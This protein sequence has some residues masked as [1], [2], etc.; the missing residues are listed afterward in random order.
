[1]REAEAA[2][3]MTVVDHWIAQGR[4]EEAM[5]ATDLL[6]RD[7]PHFVYAWA[8][9]GTAAYHLMRR[10]FME[11]YP[12]ANAIPSHLRARLVWLQRVSRESFVRADAL[13][14]KPVLR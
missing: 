12:D 5:R 13:G 9:K 2:V 14:W 3:A 4:Y 10:E 11:P 7:Y 1:M 8:K 6:L